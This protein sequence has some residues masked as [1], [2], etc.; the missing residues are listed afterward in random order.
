MSLKERV[1]YLIEPGDES[2]RL[3][4]A[5]ILLLIFLNI[6]ALMLET[7]ESV[8]ST[9]PKAFEAFED[10]SLLVFTVEYLLRLWT[11]TVVPRYAAPVTGRLRFLFTPMALIDLAAILPFFLAILGVDLRY[12]RAVRLLR[13]ARIF[14]LT[15]YSHSLRLLG[16]VMVASRNE[17]AST[18]FILVVLLLLASSSIY[19]AER[20]AQPEIFSSIPA[21]MWWGIV[22][23]TTVGY[24]DTY[25]ITV[26]G[27]IVAAFIAVLGIGMFALP[28]GILG[29]NFVEE[30][31]N[32]RR[33]KE[34]GRCCPKCGEPLDDQA[35]A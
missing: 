20:T 9:A 15:R 2:G 13:F 3:V 31:Q 21:A 10:F 8:Y 16:R 32:E 28:T 24:G 6:V 19:L 14:K 29:A 5:F 35:H 7:V 11:C 18:F 27:Q 34:G 17:L 4:D 30:L 22:T 23:L 12:V 25:P 33:R 1:Y 26:V